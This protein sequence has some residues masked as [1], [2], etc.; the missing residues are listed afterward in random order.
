MDS[1]KANTDK[2]KQHKNPPYSQRN[3]EDFVR[4]TQRNPSIYEQT[5][6]N[7]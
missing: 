5:R 1:E 4:I 6:K 3:R 2:Q 7:S